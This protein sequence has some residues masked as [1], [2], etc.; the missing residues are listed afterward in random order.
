MISNLW[1]DVELY[2]GN[3]HNEMQKMTLQQIGKQ[4]YYVC[5]SQTEEHQETHKCTNR[6]SINHFEKMLDYL[7][8][9]MMEAA[10]ASD[11]L[12]LTNL[13]W[14]KNGIEFRVIEHRNK[15]KILML[16]KTEAK[17]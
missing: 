5:P 3:N 4:M 10:L 13:R 16:N 1:D 6:I 11:E 17:L 15:I 2:C 14:K 9:T 7:S 8:E 12:N